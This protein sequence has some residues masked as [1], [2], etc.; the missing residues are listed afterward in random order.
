MDGGRPVGGSG[1]ASGK[2]GVVELSRIL[3][4]EMKLQETNIQVFT[5]GPG[6]VRTEMTDLQVQS[7][8]GRR[9]IP[10]TWEHFQSGKL[11]APE[12]I[13]RATMRLIQ[14]ARQE[15]SGS[16]YGPNYGIS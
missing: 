10:S 4:E 1:Y 7:D 3:V 11:R 8:A 12:E 14:S 5:A 2:A 6:L 9:W 13:A 15:P 16:S